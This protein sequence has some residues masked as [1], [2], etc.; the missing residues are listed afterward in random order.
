MKIVHTQARITAKKRR[1]NT[2]TRNKC[3]NRTSRL[4]RTIINKPRVASSLHLALQ[5]RYPVVV[6]VLHVR[7]NTKVSTRMPAQVRLM[8]RARLSVQ[9]WEMAATITVATSV[10]ISRPREVSQDIEPLMRIFRI[11]GKM[12][13]EW[14]NRRA[15]QFLS[16]NSFRVAHQKFI[17]GIIELFSF[18]R[19][20]LADLHL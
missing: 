20:L 15:E 17:Q 3:G 16:V 6:S 4:M 19:T 2:M 10:R 18:S 7:L 5:G 11:F 12:L 13:R 9:L 8:M 14:F 1:G